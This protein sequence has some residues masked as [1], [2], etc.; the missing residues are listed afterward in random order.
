M[1]EEGAVGDG[2]CNASLRKKANKARSTLVIISQL[3]MVHPCLKEAGKQG[4]DQ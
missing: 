2:W 4:V 3:S 1:R